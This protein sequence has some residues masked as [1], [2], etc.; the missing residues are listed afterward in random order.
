MLKG[1]FPLKRPV[2][3]KFCKPQE[4]KGGK[5]CDVGTQPMLADSVVRERGPGA[6]SS[7]GHQKMGKGTDSP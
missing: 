2:T 4:G 5:W 1:T 7:R 3:H 6:N